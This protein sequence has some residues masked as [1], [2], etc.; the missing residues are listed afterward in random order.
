VFWVFG[1]FGRRQTYTRRLFYSTLQ[2][3][4]LGKYPGSTTWVELHVV[5]SDEI[6]LKEAHDDATILKGANRDKD[7][8][9][10]A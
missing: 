6:S 5:F 1:W 8:D 10:F 9:E 4:Y 7:L 3:H 2:T